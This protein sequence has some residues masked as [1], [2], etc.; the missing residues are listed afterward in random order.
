MAYSIDFRRHIL[1]VREEERLTLI[2][3]EARFKVSKMSISRWIKELEPKRRKKKP[4]KISNEAIIEDVN[5]YRDA[6]QSERALRLGVS[7]SG[8]YHALKRNKIS[9]K[10]KFK[11]SES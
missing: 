11:P 1:K 9:Y 5:K 10:K 6:Y 2:E 4:T 7:K 3:S 8:I